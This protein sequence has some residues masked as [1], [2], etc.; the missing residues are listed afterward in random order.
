MDPCISDFWL[1]TRDKN[2]LVKEYECKEE[3]DAILGEDL[4]VN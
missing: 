2:L 4:P 1:H 3:K